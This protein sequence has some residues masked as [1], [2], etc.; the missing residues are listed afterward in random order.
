MPE[1]QTMLLYSNRVIVLHVAGRVR[2]NSNGSLEQICGNASTFEIK[3]NLFKSAFRH[4][5]GQYSL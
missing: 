4:R 1:A 5:D 2:Q 3:A